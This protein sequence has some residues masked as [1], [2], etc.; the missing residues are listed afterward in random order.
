MSWS[1]HNSYRPDAKWAK[2]DP[3]NELDE[4]EDYFEDENEEE[5]DEELEQYMNS[6]KKETKKVEVELKDKNTKKMEKKQ[7]KEHVKK[8]IEKSQ[9]QKIVTQFIEAPILQEKKKDNLNDINFKLKVKQCSQMNLEKISGLTAKENIVN[10]EWCKVYRELFKGKD[11]S[12][13]V[14]DKQGNPIP[15]LIQK[16]IKDFSFLKRSFFASCVNGTTLFIHGGTNLKTT[17][18]DLIAFDTS[19]QEIN[20][21]QCMEYLWHKSIHYDYGM[22]DSEYEIPPLSNHQM[23]FINN[24]ILIFGALAKSNYKAKY[25]WN[26]KQTKIFQD[27]MKFFYISNPLSVDN[28]HFGVRIKEAIDNHEFNL[29]DIFPHRAKH[30]QDYINR[31][32][33]FTVNEYGR[34][35]YL[36]GGHSESS[37]VGLND[38]FSITLNEL[39]GDM[40]IINFK[41]Q[42]KDNKLWTIP[43]RYGHTSGLSSGNLLIYGGRSEDTIL[44]DLWICDLEKMKWIEIIVDDIV[45]PSLYEH[46]MVVLSEKSIFIYGGKSNKGVEGTIYLCDTVTK[47]W[48]IVKVMGKNDSNF[49][50]LQIATSGNSMS[51][52]ASSAYVIGG[53]DGIKNSDTLFMINDIYD[54]GGEYMLT[55]Y[56]SQQFLEEKMTDIVI[57]IKDSKGEERKIK[58]H[59]VVLS[60]RCPYLAGLIKDKEKV[61]IVETIYEIFYPYIYFL[62][63]GNLKIKDHV[64]EL[65]TIVKKWN[66]KLYPSIESICSNLE[67]NNTVQVINQIESD[68]KAL[69]NKEDYSD[70]SLVIGDIVIP[71]HKI[72]ICRSPHFRNAFESGMSESLSNIV[73]LD[74]MEKEPIL[75]I[76][77]FLYTDQ[78]KV[79]P[80]HCVGVLLYSSMFQI[81]VLASNCRTVVTQNLNP[82][83][84]CQVIEIAETYGDQILKRLSLNYIKKNYE[85]VR[86][87]SDFDTIEEKLSK[88]IIS[89]AEKYEEQQMKKKSKK[90]IQKK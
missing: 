86:N 52:I 32:V 14:K 11:V 17:F 61:E 30:N 76:L 9:N 72:I 67:F 42:V 21:F 85:A 16:P 87:T 34:K 26:D 79:S 35:L 18:K 50:D 1:Q 59:K 27:E 56:L 2:S 80:Q 69:L 20:T 68:F 29:V 55:E 78:V 15:K 3:L 60:C 39:T 24:G 45:P 22:K 53:T 4:G 33:G 75:E 88:E 37:T 73:D 63:S 38:M 44:N 12:K 74:G 28:I 41:K 6:T 43:G 57:L 36:F 51:L 64:K 7:K 48:N 13:D 77:N 5:Y 25:S 83:N 70:C 40:T 19:K 47:E 23:V 46:S 58:A 84:V 8:G 49:G 66:E 71:A 62:Y 10:S 81:S 82:R 65:L 54:V 90:Q 89:V 31:R